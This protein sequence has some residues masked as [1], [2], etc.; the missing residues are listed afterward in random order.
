MEGYATMTSKLDQ[1]GW[2]VTTQEPFD[3]VTEH[4]LAPG[5]A[6]LACSGSDIVLS[7][8]ASAKPNAAK[9]KGRYIIMLP[10]IL[11]LRPKSKE[12]GDNGTDKIGDDEDEEDGAKNGVI[13]TD[14]LQVDV[15]TKSKTPITNLSLGRIEGLTTDTP[16]LKIPYPNGGC[17]TFQGH[18]VN[19]SSSRFMMLSFKR[20]DVFCKDAVSSVIVFGESTYSGPACT[21]A[22][23]VDDLTNYGGSDRTIDGGKSVKAKKGTRQVVKTARLT[24]LPTETLSQTIKTPVRKSALAKILVASDVDDDDSD[25]Y[26]DDAHQVRSIQ[27]LGSARRSSRRSAGGSKVSYVVDDDEDDDDEVNQGEDD[28]ESS[29]K[30]G[31]RPTSIDDGD[32]E[33]NAKKPA[34]KRAPAKPKP[35]LDSDSEEEKPSKPVRKRAPVK[36]KVLL[37]IDDEDD[38]AP[39]KP[40]AKTAPKRNATK[41]KSLVDLQDEDLETSSGKR[42]ARRS[43]P[44]KSYMEEE[45]DS[46]NSE[47]V[48]VKKRGKPSMRAGREPREVV[49]CNTAMPMSQL[50]ETSRASLMRQTKA[51]PA[52]DTGSSAAQAKGMKAKESKPVIRKRKAEPVIIDIDEVLDDESL[53]VSASRARRSNATRKGNG[54]PIYSENDDSDE[55]SDEDYAQER[56]KP[57][58]RNKAPTAP[59]SHQAVLTVIDVDESPQKELTV[60]NGRDDG[61]K[62]NEPPQKR[63]RTLFASPKEKSS[64]LPDEKSKSSASASLVK[65]S[66]R[67]RRRRKPGEGPT[68]PDAQKQQVNKIMSNAKDEYGAFDFS[69]DDIVILSTPEKRVRVKART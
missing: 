64:A 25:A 68:S 46:D 27:T 42:P 16:V 54:K 58:P 22:V 4:G 18:K 52:I 29:S 19:D 36:P 6:L 2:P 28:G 3:L 63:S 26:L 12:S 59:T 53:K 32:E 5:S 7:R 43:T 13:C 34:R 48:E 20:G 10:G 33:V 56:T 47:R 41:P 57:S 1:D 67:G 21:D 11:S 49:T 23:E 44:K 39:V 14:D 65:A 45:D 9:Q 60:S 40:V 15:A 55:S 50:S 24:Q 66:P 37:D 8:G 61:V 69:A 30:L 62:E 17:L 35:A 51:T 38:E 31:R